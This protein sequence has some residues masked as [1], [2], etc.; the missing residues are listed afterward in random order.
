MHFFLAFPLITCFVNCEVQIFIFDK[1][2]LVY[3]LCT[4]HTDILTHSVVVM[5]TELVM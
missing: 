2:N 4:T 1:R 3:Q 5:C